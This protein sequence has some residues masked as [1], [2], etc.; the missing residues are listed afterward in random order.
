MSFSILITG[1]TGFVGSHILEALMQV[2]HADLHIIAGCR[3]RKKLLPAFKGEIRTGDLRDPVY[4]DHVLAGVDIIFHAAAWTSMWGNKKNSRK[5][6][7]EPTLRLIDKALEWKSQAFY[8][9]K[10]GICC[11]EQRFQPTRTRQATCLLASSQPH[12]RNRKLHAR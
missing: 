12:D 5:L 8:Q 11:R 10:F 2:D 4:L 6:Y 9:S 3:D 7:L 1:A